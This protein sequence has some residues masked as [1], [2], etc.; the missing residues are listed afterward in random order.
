MKPLS[1]GRYGHAGILVLAMLAAAQGQGPAPAPGPI[2]ALGGPSFEGLVKESLASQRDL[3]ARREHCSIDPDR[4][5]ALGVAVGQQVRIERAGKG[6]AFFTVT[7]APDESP[8]TIVR[9]GKMGRARLDPAAEVNLAVRVRRWISHPTASDADARRLGEFV[10]RADDDGSATGM[11]ALAPHGG[12]IESRTD[13]QAVC[14]AAALAQPGKP[15]V[16]TWRC[17][18]Y[19][20]PGG[21]SASARWHITA[22]ETSEASFP[23]LARIARRQFAYFVSFHGMARE[24]ILIGGRGPADLMIALRDALTRAVKGADIPVLIAAEGETNGGT[25]PRNIVNRYCSDTGIQIEQSPR[26]RR[27]HWRAIADAVAQVYAPRL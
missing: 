20:L 10:E 3:A 18:G 15:P 5:R 23:L 24:A 7:E 13:E 16:T 6:A 9:L 25:S 19:D 17:L 2:D 11:L 21:A 27:D 26:A 8:D 12:M 4:L 22:T 14:L 1:A